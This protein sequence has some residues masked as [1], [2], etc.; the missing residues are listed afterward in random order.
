MILDGFLMNISKVLKKTHI[1]QLKN[2]YVD[3]KIIGMHL[4][5]I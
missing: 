2:I 1:L 3:L 5:P 4:Q